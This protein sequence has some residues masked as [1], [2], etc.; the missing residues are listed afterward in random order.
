MAILISSSTSSTSCNNLLLGCSKGAK[1]MVY[2]CPGS[3]T[4]WCRI[5]PIRPRH[6]CAMSNDPAIPAYC[7]PM[8]QL[9]DHPIVLRTTQ[10]P[11]MQV[12]EDK[13]PV[14][15]T[16]G[17]FLCPY[18]KPLRCIVGIFLPRRLFVA[19][20]TT[21]RGLLIPRFKTVDRQIDVRPRLLNFS[22]SSFLIMADDMFLA[23]ASTIGYSVVAD[24]RPRLD[25]RET[26]M[27]CCLYRTR[28]RLKE[29]YQAVQQT[30]PARW[31]G[32]D[33]ALL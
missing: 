22:L 6:G 3:S 32:N 20:T 12:G 13:V 5:C 18:T 8:I 9:Y 15:C 21:T 30:S 2:T 17:L 14:R 26:M 19:G 25:G 16:T 28:Q 23:G 4:D 29:M 10:S 24:K 27:H 33:D 1:Q 31:Q 7:R 11:A